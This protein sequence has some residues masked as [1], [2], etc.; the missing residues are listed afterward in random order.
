MFG[1]LIFK[2]ITGPTN[3]IHKLSN[4]MHTFAPT[5]N[6]DCLERVAY[7]RGGGFLASDLK[8]FK[9]LPTFK[10]VRIRV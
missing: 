3:T 8:S 7:V 2:T 5:P 1:T 9:N 6:V 4:V 10:M